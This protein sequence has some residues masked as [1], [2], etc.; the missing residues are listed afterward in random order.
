M[1][2]L[3]RLRRPD[4]QAI[5]ATLRVVNH[6]GPSPFFYRRRAFLL[7]PEASPPLLER[8]LAAG[9]APPGARCGC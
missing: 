4:R 2:N 3:L 1:K 5:G 9:A 6:P 7:R 8:E